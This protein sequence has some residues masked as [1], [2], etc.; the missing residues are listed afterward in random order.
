MAFSLRSFFGKGGPGNGAAASIQPPDNM[1][2]APIASPFQSVSDPGF[3]NTMLFKTADAET[4]AGAPVASTPFT[5]ATGSPVAGLTIGDLLPF[6]PPDVA[7]HPGLPL[8]HPVNLPESVLDGALRSGRPSIPLF[9]LSRVCPM[10]FLAQ[11]GPHDPREV[12]LPPHKIAHLIPPNRPAAPPQSPFSLASEQGTTPSS[13]PFGSALA[14]SEA[15]P[16]AALPPDETSS[17]FN[18]TPFGLMAEPAQSPAPTADGDAQANPPSRPGSFSPFSSAPTGEPA[19]AASPFVSA[20]AMTASSPFSLAPEPTSATPGDAPPLFSA[21]SSFAT[22]PSPQP[23]PP[24]PTF[25]SMFGGPVVQSVPGVGSSS[26]DSSFLSASAPQDAAFAPAPAPVSPFLVEPPSNQPAMPPASLGSSPFQLPIESATSPMP[27]VGAALFAASEPPRSSGATS[28]ATPVEAPP[29]TPFVNSFGSP[30]APSAPVPSGFGNTTTST[31]PGQGSN[32]AAFPAAPSKPFNP[33]ERIQALAKAAENA[34]PGTADPFSKESTLDPASLFGGSPLPPAPQPPPVA[35]SPVMPPPAAPVPG[36]REVKLDL[37]ASL[38]N[39]AAHDLGTNPENIPSWVQFT[40]R[41]DMVA[42]QLSTGR[43]VVP[44]DAIVAGLDAPIRMLFSQARS[45]V[46]VELPVSAVS[47]AVSSAPSMPPTAPAPPIATEASVPSALLDP[48]SLIPENAWEEKES[49]P[50]A[51][52]FWSAA[53]AAAP[54]SSAPQQVPGTEPAPIPTTAGPIPAPIPTAPSA[55]SGPVIIPA[56][57]LTGAPEFVSPAPVP[58]PQGSF[59]ADATPRSDN[60]ARRL[61]LHV[62]LGS[63]DARDAASVVRLTSQ[64]PGVAAALCVKD[65]RL[66]C[67]SGGDTPDSQRFLRDAPAKINGL[68]A[69]ASLTGIDDAET[70]HIQSGQVEATFCMQGTMTFAVLHDPRRREPALKE[71]ITLLGREL[72]AMLGT[73]AAT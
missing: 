49:P 11:V 48:F 4:P 66:I 24:L 52:P 31:A 33:F 12:P 60:A 32:P 27:G 73:S 61:L 15:A 42:S 65:N 3:A 67:E 2:P 1:T 10:M 57:P 47:H 40:L 34:A 23:S 22:A 13:S 50:A 41:Y 14:A 44:L 6:I 26:Q 5:P 17:L 7:K 9:E 20:P 38:K 45:G 56:N 8:T 19:M 63:P 58:P 43:V 18:P 30:A 70:L 54:A 51:Q 55:K 53:A 68:T 59:I 62:L 37:A 69:L 35:H 46:Q 28:R 39:C 25:P 16:A 64:L 29:P 21:D 36:D 71:K 72:A